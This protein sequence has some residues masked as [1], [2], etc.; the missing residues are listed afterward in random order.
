MVGKGGA[1]GRAVPNALTREPANI[2]G[3]YTPRRCALPAGLERSGAGNDPATLLTRKPG[4]LSTTYVTPVIPPSALSGAAKVLA[5]QSVQFG[6]SRMRVKPTI[7][8]RMRIYVQFQNAAISAM[9]LMAAST[10]F[11]GLT[12]QQRDW[13]GAERFMQKVEEPAGL[14]GQALRELFV[15]A[16]P[17]VG[18]AAEQVTNVLGAT[19]FGVDA[20]QLDEALVPVNM[21][22]NEFLLAVRIDLR[23]DLPYRRHR[24]QVWRPRRPTLDSKKKTRAKWRPFSSDSGSA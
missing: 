12:E 4:A 3:G 17:E 9:S 18:R 15:V 23:V 24:W 19:G 16:S 11:R 13:E 10:T 5:Q 1:H 20:G 6:K 14:L 8:D 22:L 2:A 21:A 7:Q